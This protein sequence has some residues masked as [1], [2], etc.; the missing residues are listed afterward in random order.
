VH[1]WLRGSGTS[2]LTSRRVATRSRHDTAMGDRRRKTVAAGAVRRQ[3]GRMRQRDDTPDARVRCPAC[4]HLTGLIHWDGSLLR[5]VARPDGRCAFKHARLWAIRRTLSDAS[6]RL[7]PLQLRI[8]SRRQGTAKT[9][10]CPTSKAQ[11][12]GRSERAARV[13][14][15][16]ELGTPWI[17]ICGLA[18]T[19][20]AASLAEATRHGAERDRD[21][22]CPSAR[23]WC[24]LPGSSR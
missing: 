9:C 22:S 20:C 4:K 7:R 12:R 3:A 10:I 21:C 5:R 8:S 13:C 15:S 11:Q 18:P 16:R 14:C 6:C 23:P 2:R 24:A 1:P 19:S 17:T